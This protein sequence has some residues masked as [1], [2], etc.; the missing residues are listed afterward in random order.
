[1][2]TIDRLNGSYGRDTVRIAAAGCGKY[3]MQRN[4]LSPRY[5]TNLNEVIHVKA[6][7]N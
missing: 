5:T 1:M 2:K 3:E 7:E 6:S 4:M